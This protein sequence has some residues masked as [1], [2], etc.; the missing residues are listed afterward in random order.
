MADLPAGRQ[1]VVSNNMGYCVYIIRSVGDR[2]YYTGIT[3]DLRRRL[4]EHNIGKSSTP[5][6]K[7]RGPFVLIHTEDG[8][9]LQEAR[10]RETYLKSGVGREWRN[11]FL[12][13]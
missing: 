13:G 8:L 6:T 11:K 5:S 2:K 9:T 3:N 4:Q 10:R 12:P 7:N 1:G